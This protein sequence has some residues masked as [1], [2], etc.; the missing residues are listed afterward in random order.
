MGGY[1]DPSMNPYLAAYNYNQNFKMPQEQVTFVNG[2][3][4]AEACKLG[5]NSSKLCMDSSG[6]FLWVITTDGAGSMECVA[7]PIGDPIQEKPQEQQSDISSGM[8]AVSAYAETLNAYT[9]MLEARIAKLEE[10]VNEHTGYITATKQEPN[11][12]QYSGENISSRNLNAGA[13]PKS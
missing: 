12:L 11:E 10:Q 8:A 4:G 1:Y 3:K 9:S 5:P 6:Q 13:E 7:Y 2:R